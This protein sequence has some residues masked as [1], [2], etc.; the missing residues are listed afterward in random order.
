M[1]GCATTKIEEPPKPREQVT[2]EYVCAQ[3]TAIT[4]VSCDGL[5]LPIIVLSKIVRDHQMNW[6]GGLRGLYYPGEP[7]IFIKPGLDEELTWQIIT[8]EMSHYVLDWMD[9]TISGCKHEEYARFIA[10]QEPDEWRER[11]GCLK[12]EPTDA[13]ASI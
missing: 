10:G 8:H 7:Y 2:F 11:Y 5:G 3:A 9:P 1:T 4:G 12:E 13:E 6:G